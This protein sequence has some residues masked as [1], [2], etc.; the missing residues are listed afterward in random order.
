M[1]KTTKEDALQWYAQNR[2]IYKKLSEKVS[3]ILIELLDEAGLTVH[4]ITNR[5]KDID[6][7]KNKIDTKYEDPI[8]QVTDLSGIRIIAYV[9][10]DLKLICGIIEDTFQIDVN[11]SFNKSDELGTDKVGY[12]SIHYIARIKDDRIS[13]PEYKK[14]KELKFEIQVRTILQHAWAEIEHDKNYKFRGVLPPEIKR[15]FKIIAG[16]LELVDR[17]FNLL[18]LE[19]DKIKQEVQIATDSQTLDKIEIN[20][21]T[22]REFLLEKFTSE[23]NEKRISDSFDNHEINITE[24]VIDY[25][26][27]NLQQLN[28]LFTEKTMEVIKKT[29]LI[30]RINLTSVV[31]LA[32]LI[33]DYKKYFEKSWKNRWLKISGDFIKVLETD[34]NEIVEEIKKNAIEIV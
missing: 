4:A 21:T 24:E 25:G 29:I 11:N 27:N 13:L 19:I 33:N 31:R 23:I 8:N 26:I 16:T 5:T 2:E 14:F 34:N 9:E 28:S 10:D 30:K 6:S 15:R 7:F 22:V 1:A 32:L 17:E 18:S 20:T 3:N 12:R